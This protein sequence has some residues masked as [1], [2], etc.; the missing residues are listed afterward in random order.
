RAP[1][2]RGSHGPRIPRGLGCRPLS[3][4]AVP[5]LRGSLN[6]RRRR[7]P[8]CH[9][10][11]AATRCAICFPVVP[12][13]NGFGH[14]RFAPSWRRTAARTRAGSVPAR[15]FDP[16]SRVSGRSVFSRKVTHGTRKKQLSSW[17]PPESVITIATSLSRSSMSRQP[18]GSIRR[19]DGSAAARFSSPNSC[20][21][22]AVRGWIGKTIGRPAS[23]AASSNAFRARASCAFRSTFS[24]RWNVR[25]MYP[26]RVRPSRARTSDFFSAIARFWISAS[27]TLFPTTWTPAVTFSCPRFFREV[28]VGAKRTSE[29]W[30]ATIRFSSSGMVL[31][32]DRVHLDDFRAG[33]DDRDDAAHRRR[34]ASNRGPALKIVPRAAQVETIITA[35]R[36]RAALLVSVVTTVRNEA[37]NIAALLD[38]LIVQEPPFEINVVDSASQDATRDIVRGYERQNE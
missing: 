20:S 27:I 28:A 26:R 23:S 17:S 1:D 15:T 7:G 35:T 11:N 6:E 10:R 32:N 5:G 38:S 16:I 9:P 2:P 21:R 18:V 31:S 22:F 37:R 3:R 12:S 8:P 25:S 13:P 19:R 36:L 24:A 14:S 4:Y 30:S 29:S 34:R 33:P